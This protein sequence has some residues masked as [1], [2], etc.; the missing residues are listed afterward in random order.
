MK[1]IKELFLG[2][3]LSCMLL[4]CGSVKD[5][6]YLQGDKLLAKTAMVDT[7]YL[8][9]QKDDL[10]DIS[11]SC[12]DPELL[13]PFLQYGNGV[14][15]GGSNY[16]YSGG[17]NNKGYLVEVDGT[18]NFPL[19]GRVKVAGLTRR[20]VGDLIQSRLETG[21]YMKDPIVM[22]RFLNFRISILGEVDRPGTYQISSERI[23]LFEAL[24]LAGD[25]TIHGRRNR[26]AV[27]RE[28]DGVRTILYH[29]L[30]S[31]DIFQSPDYFL[32]QNDMVYVEPN[33]VRAEASAG[34]F[35]SVGTWT[36]L[37]SLLISVSILLF[38]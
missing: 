23:T 29:D 25:L 27:I 7:F 19:L 28:T 17:N 1:E 8:E 3:I 15:G 12:V 21:G 33:R 36:G 14:D 6:A 35:T 13:R 24:S 5:I 30:R 34:Q 18:I 37:A 20:Q 4:S 2:W 38:K 26:V 32:K 10:L 16:G 11:V 22:V 31:R 9:I